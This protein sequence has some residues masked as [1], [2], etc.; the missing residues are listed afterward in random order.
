L[1]GKNPRSFG[2]ETQQPTLTYEQKLHERDNKD[3]R[4]AI[5]LR[6]GLSNGRG[7][8]LISKTVSLASTS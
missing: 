4:K 1:L 6:M 5:M 3:R 8:Q 7:D 2:S